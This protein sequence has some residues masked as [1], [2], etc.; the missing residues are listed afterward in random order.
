MATQGTVV[1]DT[2]ATSGAGVGAG[3]GSQ[4]TA[5]ADPT[6]A[7]AAAFTCARPTFVLFGDSITQQS[8]SEKGCWG[9]MVADAWTR[10]VD[11]VNRGFSGYTTRWCVEPRA[12]GGLRVLLAG[13]TVR[14][15]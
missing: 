14:V 6:V 9:A 12:F 3:A 15:L 5:A 13:D 4:A 2:G 10:C 1:D 11:V 7:R 8:F